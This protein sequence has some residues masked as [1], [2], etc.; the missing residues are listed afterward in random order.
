MTPI[1]LDLPDEVA[2]ALR[3]TKKRVRTLVHLGELEGVRMGGPR[4]LRIVRASVSRFV[5]RNRVG[6]AS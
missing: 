6:G 1:E 3:I 4:S 2:K 5:E